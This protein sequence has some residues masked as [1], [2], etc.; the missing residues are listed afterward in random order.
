MTTPVIAHRPLP[1][2]KPSKYSKT[3]VYLEKSNG[4]QLTSRFLSRFTNGRDFYMYI[5]ERDVPNDIKLKYN[6]EFRNGRALVSI[7][8]G[9]YGLPHA[10]KLAQDRLML[11]LSKHGYHQCA[12]TYCLFRHESDDIA[13][14]VVVDDFGIL[15]GNDDSRER[16]FEVL[17]LQ[18][19]ITT[20]LTGF[21]YL[22]IDIVHNLKN[23]TVS[24]SMPG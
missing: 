23:D 16:F 6:I 22:G 19:A 18:Y 15:H 2:S 11:H 1:P 24:L 7:H 10:G 4:V 12:R 9:M 3:Y 21:K 8:K 14:M 17:R 5:N 13:F 20:D